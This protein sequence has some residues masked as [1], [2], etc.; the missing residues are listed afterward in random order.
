MKNRRQDFVF[1][2]GRI[3]LS[4]IGI[5]GINGI[6]LQ[7]QAQS[8]GNGAYGAT[9]ACAY[10]V[11]VGDA[12]E[13][14]RDNIDKLKKEK[15][16]L[17]E[18]KKK[19]L[20]K[21]RELQK[22]QAKEYE[23]MGEKV[24]A[25]ES[26]DWLIFLKRKAG[27]IED[28][29]DGYELS[30]QD[31]EYTCQKILDLANSVPA[32]KP[33]GAPSPSV[34]AAEVAPSANVTAKGEVKSEAI[35]A[36]PLPAEQTLGTEKAVRLGGS[37][38]TQRFSPAGRSPAAEAE[39]SSTNSDFNKDNIHGF[40]ARKLR[41]AKVCPV[42][43]NT[44]SKGYCQI[45]MDL[46]VGQRAEK[47]NRPACEKALQTI[48]KTA[49]EF[50]KLKLQL[51][52][53]GD[54]KRGINDLI[55]AKQEKIEG[56]TE[57]FKKAATD[58]QKELIKKI[59]EGD[60]QACVGCMLQGNVIMGARKPSTGE[61]AA[62]FAT[63]VA[64]MIAGNSLQKYAMRLNAEGG[65]PYQGIPVVGY[66]LAGGLSAGLF[67]LL[68]QGTSAGSFGCYGGA[69]GLGAMGAAGAY[70]AA[71]G[72]GPYSNLY[73]YPPKMYGTPY[74]GGAFYPGAGGQLNGNINLG[75]L[76]GGNAGL[77]QG[78]GAAFP[79]AGANWGTQF[80]QP[81]WD[82]QVY[83]N[84]G[85]PYLNGNIYA[86]AAG[87]AY[88]AGALYPAGNIYAGANGNY[89][90]PNVYA[91]SALAGAA[92][93]GAAYPAGGAFPIGSI[94]AGAALAGAAYPAGAYPAG[95]SYPAGGIADQS[96]A[97]AAY[98]AQAQQQLQ[99][100][101]AQLQAQQ[102]AIQA[103]VQQ[104]SQLNNLFTELNSVYSRINQ[105]KAGGAS[106]GTSFDANFSVGAGFNMNS[107]YNMNS[108]YLNGGSNYSLPSAVN[109][110]STLNN[111]S[112]AGGLPYR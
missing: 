26:E 68:G 29:E 105:V 44:L 86:G 64:S 43:G 3:G 37:S 33:S 58:Y 56:K 87:A 72:A 24:F 2:I 80:G 103:Q 46:P 101:N 94:Y 61:I 91:G 102:R 17:E 39:V 32:P 83:A 90:Y 52:G 48:Q 18:K 35:V 53:D 84:G 57:N 49:A 9:S 14:I 12:A 98:A 79:A 112:P 4:L 36:A 11:K 108:S 10:E 65:Y 62:N 89:P 16:S 25:S 38:T 73:G 104:A 1:K 75:A 47:A 13:G 82:G 107:G 92:Y 15:A 88:P 34:G 99:M 70:G 69:Q 31:P 85:N 66:G 59:Q 27:V 28:A 67:G 40:P 106:G 54:K 60:T 55:E 95:S 8:W 21:M 5:I 20:D 71:G 42:P 19:I 111:T 7:A 97:M 45:A 50:A 96:A 51:D 23:I 93:A 6:S 100:A 30:D 63:G 81:N 22:K 109:P 41:D 78:A 74:G 110:N 76:L 77:Y